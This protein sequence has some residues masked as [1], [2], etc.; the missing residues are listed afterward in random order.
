MWHGALYLLRWG[1]RVFRGTWRGEIKSLG[2]LLSP[3]TMSFWS[4]LWDQRRGGK[5][6]PLSIILFAWKTLWGGRKRRIIHLLPHL[7]Q[8]FVSLS[9]SKLFWTGECTNMGVKML[10][11][12]QVW[13]FVREL[14]QCLY[15]LRRWQAM[16][17]WL[18]DSNATKVPEMRN[19]KWFL[20]FHW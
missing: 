9:T 11:S 19:T 8:I 12:N 10:F 17:W 18:R 15:V 13:W 16:S 7:S 14:P 4:Y 3:S 20:L 1:K 2:A 5:Y 6:S